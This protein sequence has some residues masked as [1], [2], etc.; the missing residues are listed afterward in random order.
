MP[1]LFKV[2]CGPNLFLREA[3]VTKQQRKDASGE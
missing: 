3:E 2:I 1:I